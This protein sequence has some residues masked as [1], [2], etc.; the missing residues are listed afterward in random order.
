MDRESFGLILFSIVFYLHHC[1]P[2]LSHV[3]LLY[4][5]ATSKLTMENMPWH[6]D[7][8]AFSEA[9]ALKSEG[10]FEVACEHAHSC[11][12]LLAKTEKFKVNGDWYTWIDYEKFH[13][14]VSNSIKFIISSVS[15]L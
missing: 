12:V 7:V 1:L 11:C 3:D 6:S 13:D 8:K 2:L 15:E 14:L 10:E 5:S 9:L 4:S